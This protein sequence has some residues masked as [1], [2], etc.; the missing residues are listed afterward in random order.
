MMLNALPQTNSKS[1]RDTNVVQRERLSHCVTTLLTDYF[2]HFDEQSPPTGIYEMV[3]AEVEK[4]LLAIVMEH[5]DQ[6]QTQAARVLGISRS[7][8]RKKLA[9][10]Q[11]D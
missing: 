10:Y 3:L 5:M 8:L 4:P 9:K 7:T 11:M 6:N 2:S 1:S